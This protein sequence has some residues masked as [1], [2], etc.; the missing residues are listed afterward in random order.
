LYTPEARADL[1]EEWEH[2]ALSWSPDGK[3]LL[4]P[5][6][7]SHGRSMIY[8]LD[9][10]TMD[11]KPITSPSEKID[12][13]FSPAYSPDGTHIA[14][15]RG[16]EGFV[17]DVYVRDVSGGEPK[18]LTFDNRYVSSL[19]WT[20][21]GS[22]IIFSSD[23]AGKTS[24]WRVD[25]AGGEPRR[26]PFGEDALA[27]AVARSGEMLA[28]AQRS[29]KWSIIRV[30]LGPASP[31]N[32]ATKLL[33]STEQDSAPR[34]SPDGT[35]I[36][37]QSWRS[38]TQE[39]WVCSS[40]GTDL[41]KLTSY[42]G[43]LT[44]SPSWS[45]DGQQIAFDSRPDG[46]SH[47]YVIG[48]NGGVARAMTNGEYNDIVPSWSQ[49]GQWIYFGSNRSGGWEIW[50]VAASGGQPQQVTRQGGFVGLPSADGKWVYFAKS[51]QAGIW[52]VAAS[53][54]EQTRV[55]EEPALG[56]WA[57]WTVSGKSIYYLHQSPNA[58]SINVFHTDTGRTERIRTLDRS[59][60]TYSG[61]TVSP[62]GKSLVYTDLTEAGSHIT[63]VQNFR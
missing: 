3:R 28:Y 37:F 12:G 40:S 5:D 56:N 32:A 38:G 6:G 48:V 60:A 31:N 57:S 17:R 45:P 16:T 9:L 44:G 43:P 11:A 39:I 33:S 35:K 18:R 34:Y 24:L 49:D 15:A 26:L 2:G 21:D 55:M 14:F 19:A 13:D 51:D 58:T 27:P 59:P 53:G 52:R 22:G 42:G 62:D 23:R 47:I 25:L 36:A 41:V 63:L 4:F 50:R 20:A 30:P 1:K 10:A 61:S 7:K 29:A 54:G 46:R 8:A